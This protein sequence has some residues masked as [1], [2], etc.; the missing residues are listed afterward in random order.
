MTVQ[1]LTDITVDDLKVLISELI[2]A[3]LQKWSSQSTITVEPE[4][5]YL[6]NSASKK[7]YLN[8]EGKYIFL[9][10]TPEEIAR[11]AQEVSDMFD[12][13]DRKYD[14]EEQKETFAYLQK[15][16]V[17]DFPPESLLPENLLSVSQ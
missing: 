6:D 16:L 4:S 11:Y 14:V 1:K 10:R 17:D 2:A 12:E 5:K 9:E 13:W 15:A 7:P 3:E 8:S